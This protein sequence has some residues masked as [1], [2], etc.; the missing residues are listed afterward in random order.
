[1]N[2]QSNLYNK[3]K[4]YEFLNVQSTMPTVINLRC[5]CVCVQLLS[6]VPTLYNPMDCSLPGSSV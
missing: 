4:R 1:M 5:V 6:H 2:F 3:V